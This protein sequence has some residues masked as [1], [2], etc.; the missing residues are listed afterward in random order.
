MKS[1][2]MSSF[3]T[4]LA[5]TASL[6]V[7]SCAQADNHRDIVDTA[8]EAGTFKTLAAA[9]KTAGRVHTLLR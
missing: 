4:A 9:L 5:L 1:F 3:A 8:V 7:S 6:S 2:R